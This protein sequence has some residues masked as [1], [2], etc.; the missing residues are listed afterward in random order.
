MH[1]TQT[2]YDMTDHHH[3]LLVLSPEACSVA[4]VHDAVVTTILLLELVPP[5]LKVAKGTG[6]LVRCGGSMFPQV[7][8]QGVGVRHGGTV[9]LPF[10]TLLHDVVSEI[11]QFQRLDLLSTIRKCIVLYHKFICSP[12]NPSL[13]CFFVLFFL[14]VK[15]HTS[16]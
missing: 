16:C 14:F 1:T 2:I 3:H 12:C 5:L 10:P 15:C 11:I 9:L 8:Q 13:Q 7:S 4:S 6:I